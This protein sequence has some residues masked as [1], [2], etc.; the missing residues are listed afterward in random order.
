VHE[1]VTINTDPINARFNYE[2]AAYLFFLIS[3]LLYHQS[4]TDYKY[5]S[6][7]DCKYQSITDYKYT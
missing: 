7:T 5:Q 4:I 2:T 6:I 3:P 1:L